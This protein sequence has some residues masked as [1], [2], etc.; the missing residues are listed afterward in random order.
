MSKFRGAPSG[1][2]EVCGRYVAIVKKHNE[3]LC[4]IGGSNWV[5]TLEFAGEL[6]DLANECLDLSDI[7]AEQ[8]FH[9]TVDQPI[10]RAK[11]GEAAG[12]F[13]P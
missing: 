3:L 1:S 10:S 12:D 7:I 2:D 4:N 11:P 6:E 8:L 5:P 9:T 13:K